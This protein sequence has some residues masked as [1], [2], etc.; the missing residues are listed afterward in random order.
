MVVLSCCGSKYSQDDSY[1]FTL[2]FHAHLQRELTDSPTTITEHIT[3]DWKGA[4]E[5]LCTVFLGN[6]GNSPIDK[7]GIFK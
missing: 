4:K 1:S 3:S 7:D 5:I 2:Y 6:Y